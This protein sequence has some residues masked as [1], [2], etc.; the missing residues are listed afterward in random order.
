[1]PFFFPPQP[2][3]PAA[4]TP[5]RRNPRDSLLF[6]FSFY[7]RGNDPRIFVSSTQTIPPSPSSQERSRCLLQPP[8]LPSTHA[9]NRYALPPATKLIAVVRI[10]DPPNRSA[11]ALA[12]PI[13]SDL[14]VQ[15]ATQIAELQSIAAVR[16]IQIDFDATTSEHDFYAALLRDVRRRL[17]PDLSLS[18]TAL[19]SWCIGDS[20]LD[21]LA[22]GTI[23]E[24]VPMLFR[25][26]AGTTNVVNFCR[27][28]QKFRSTV[29]NASLGLSTDE[30]LSRSILAGESSNALASRA[31]KRIYIFAPH[32]WT[33]RQANSLLQE[34]R[35]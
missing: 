34:L 28:N 24:A 21:T 1:M 5:R 3:P 11:N 29:C 10:E 12:L 16:A 27:A 7:G 25:M 8:P 22:P 2:I 32:P 13:N 15:L 9:F 18:I 33:E 23:D 35:P 26:G 30:S 19:A 31:K 4:T 6:P 20:W 17:R 14:R